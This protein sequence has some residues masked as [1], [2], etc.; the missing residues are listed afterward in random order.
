MSCCSSCSK[1]GECK[2]KG[3][4]KEKA[5]SYISLIESGSETESEPEKAINYI[6]LTL[7]DDNDEKDES[8][9]EV[10]PGMKE[11]KKLRKQL[12]PKKKVSSLG[13]R[14]RSELF[15]NSDGYYSPQVIQRYRDTPRHAGMSLEDLLNI[16]HVPSNLAVADPFLN[17]TYVKQSQHLLSHGLNERGLYA[18]KNIAKGEII[19]VYPPTA[20]LHEDELD[21]DEHIAYGIQNLETGMIDVIHPRA[22]HTN[23]H[24]A[25]E[26]KPPF[27]NPN[28]EFVQEGGITVLEA[29]Q[30]IPRY[31]EIL[32]DY[33]PTYW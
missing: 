16:R 32:V 13:G 21:E 1:G 24:F 33:G 20:L 4:E 12:K 29:L 28:A 3:K 30:D 15:L 17:S 2:G 23:A 8:D 31:Q 22:S 19:A 11:R 9:V 6:N 10:V 27:A 5:I 7:S 14:S 26:G 18:R 25:N